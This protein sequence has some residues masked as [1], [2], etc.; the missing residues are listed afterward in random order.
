MTIGADPR[1]AGPATGWIE[2]N[3][4]LLAAVW[5]VF[6]VFPAIT[7][8]S[9]DDETARTKWAAIGLLLVFSAL[10]ISG[11]HIQNKAE[12]EARA[13]PEVEHDL[14]NGWY[15]LVGL[16]L[17]TVALY[18][19][20]DL[21]AIGV[22]PFVVSFAVFL[23]P[24]PVVFVVFAVGVG[25]TVGLPLADGSFGDLW[26]MSL[27]I[28]AVG[29][30]TM[31]IRVVESHQVEQTRLR[32]VLAVSDERTRVARDVHDVLGHSLTAVVLKVE[33][34]RRYLADVDPDD[35]IQRERID[36]CRAQLDELEAISRGAL[37]EIRSTVGGLRAANLSDEVT[38]ARTVLADA[39][40]GLLVTGE[41]NDVPEHQRPTMAWVVREAVT[42]IVRHARASQCHIE[43]A[44]A[45]GPVL[46]RV[47]DDGVGI[48]GNTAG[49]GLRGLQERVEAVGAEL[50]VGWPDDSNGMRTGGGT[51]VE[52]VVG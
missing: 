22:V 37:A 7:I 19:L 17:T 4:W 9:L 39:G 14:P 44:P 31:L 34:A 20:V 16:V 50:R 13:Q 3:G 43:L 27:I 8:A 18:A 1:P 11:F 26:F 36:A 52:V 49:N 41:V 35:P 51:R 38:V 46:L 42:N 29:G 12:N 6:L 33:L 10:Y 40:V 48:A 24:W 2:R 47:S 21:P 45:D 25:V 30:A 15:H 23:F 5:L 28:L 32:T